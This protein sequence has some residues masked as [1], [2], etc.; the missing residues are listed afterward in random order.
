MKTQLLILTA[1][2]SAFA[3][4]A[5]VTLV[6]EI[7]DNGTSS[8]LPANLTEFGGIIYFGADDSNGSNTPGGA[9]LGK[10]LWI[11]DGTG[12]G[13]T[14]VK[15]LRTGSASSSPSFF[16]EY[17]S[18]LYFSAN[19]GAGNVLHSTDG[20]AVG[21]T[22]TGGGFVFN[23]IELN[24]LIY[25]VNTTD[26]NGLW[27][28]DGTT[29]VNVTDA[30]AGAENLS[31][32]VLTVFNGKIFCYMNYSTDDVTIGNEL[33]SYEPTT[34]VFT[35]IKDITGDDANSGI[36][37][38]TVMGSELY[39]EALGALWKTDGTEVG[40]VAVAAAVSLGGVGNLVAF[41]GKVL[42]EGDNGTSNDQLWSYDPLGD[43]ITNVSNITGSVATGG[44]NHDPSDY[45]EL[46]G[47][48]YYAGEVSDETVQ[49][50]FRTDG[51]TSTRL[52][53]SIKDI[54]DLAVLSNVLYFEGDN[55]TT[56]NELYK[57]DPASLSV[58]ENQLEIV[59]VYP[60]PATD[61]ILVSNNL[62]NA[63]YA[64]YDITGKTVKQGTINSEKINLDLN[65]GLYLFKVE[66]ELSTVTKK[67]IIK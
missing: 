36:S 40:T 43:T 56:G 44:N 39:F 49:Y 59:S 9:D 60:N 12:G 31:G 17:N 65:S 25:Y 20:T 67:I 1:L 19:T 26:S 62:M 32:A 41:N 57:F 38:F 63:S 50:L 54:D 2:I 15:D 28:F 35:L 61:Y 10:E 53:S 4:N 24:G 22:S 14:F 51:T 6:K 46:D 8:S 48:L 42:F 66:T 3:M 58:G 29:Q 52:D 18:T 64:I 7:N 5:Q 27:E 23:P 13:T 30:G 21:T 37:N 33:Y 45:A 34:D 55:G 47:F 11:T 16:F